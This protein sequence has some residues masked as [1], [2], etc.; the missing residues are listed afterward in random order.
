MLSLL[1]EQVIRGDLANDRDE[2][3]TYVKKKMR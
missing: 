1:L 3:L 2:L